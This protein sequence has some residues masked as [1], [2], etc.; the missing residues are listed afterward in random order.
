MVAVHV[1]NHRHVPQ[2]LVA[3][4][5]RPARGVVESGRRGEPIPGP[6]T[7]PPDDK[8]RNTIS[9][10]V[11]QKGFVSETGT[12]PLLGKRHRGAIA[13]ARTER[14]PWTWAWSPQGELR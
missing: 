4:L 6:V 2:S 11:A 14:E 3:P 12:S 9:V 13:I 8:I 5:F 7:R 10:D 1:C